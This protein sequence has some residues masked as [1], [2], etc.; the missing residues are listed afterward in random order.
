MVSQ[1]NQYVFDS[2]VS[3][4]ITCKVHGQQK[5]SLKVTLLF[6]RTFE[7]IKIDVYSSLV[8]YFVVEI[9]RFVLYLNDIY[10]FLENHKYL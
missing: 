1:G 6:K 9:L 10:D 4:S 2:E 8:S 3:L 5:F 7:V